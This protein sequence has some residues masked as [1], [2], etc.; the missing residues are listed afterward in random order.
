MDNE[1]RNLIRMTLDAMLCLLGCVVRGSLVDNAVPGVSPASDPDPSDLLD[2]LEDEVS[3]GNLF[4]YKKE[5]V[6]FLIRQSRWN[7]NKNRHYDEIMY[8]QWR[9]F[10]NTWISLARLLG[11]PKSTQ[12][13]VQ[14]QGALED[15]LN[16]KASAVGNEGEDNCS[17]KLQVLLRLLVSVGYEELPKRRRTTHP[18]ANPPSSKRARYSP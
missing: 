3:N 5:R 14:L 13:L 17:E 11:A 2:I 6:L 18:K 15:V 1:T 12:K 4:S 9:K 7:R 16:E 8:K 10:S